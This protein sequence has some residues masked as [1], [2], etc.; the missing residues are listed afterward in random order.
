MT[1]STD[2][3]R[4]DVSAS[5]HA[6]ETEH[7]AAA[8]TPAGHDAPKWLWRS[9]SLVNWHSARVHVNAVGHASASAIFEGIRAYRAADRDSLLVFRLEDHLRRLYDSARICR[10]DLRHNLPEL[11]EAVVALLRANEYRDDAYVRPWAF[12]SGF[13]KE[14]MVPADSPCEVIVDSW[15]LD[16]T[17]LAPEGCRAAVSSWLRI[18]E[19]SMP[20]R[21]KAFSNYHNGRLAL[22]EARENGHDW[23]VLLNERHKVT[24]GA[25]ACLAL[26]RNG[27]V[28]TPSLTSG[29]LEGLTRAT[30][31]TLIE[32]VLGLGV[33]QR[34]VDRT[35]L[36]LADEIF[37]LG[38][39]WEILPVLSIDG[40]RVG[41]GTPGPVALQLR[42]E[43]QQV[44]RGRSHRYRHWLT[45][46]PAP[47]AP[48]PLF[49]S[50]L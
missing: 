4:Q 11:S 16:S 12:P 7:G 14:Q 17:L 18:S 33:E 2:P 38:T 36:Y 34:E 21:V 31:I 29:V 23:P 41:D 46:I 42:H 26:V 10:L 39:A 20:P 37:F 35:E 50:N 22:L 13:I 24:E 9:G 1:N 5:P 8:D 3:T 19:S 25:G 48:S 49:P 28:I 6:Y 43:Y 15:A 40:L 47:K 32:E 45:E 44:V 30:A 27:Q